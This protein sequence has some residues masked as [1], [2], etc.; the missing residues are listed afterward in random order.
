MPLPPDDAPAN[1]KARSRFHSGT[2]LLA[3]GLIHFASVSSYL[4]DDETAKLAFAMTG[5]GAKA[6]PTEPLSL[7]SSVAR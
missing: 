5:A 6:P 4:E 7:I 2:G 1:S 3:L